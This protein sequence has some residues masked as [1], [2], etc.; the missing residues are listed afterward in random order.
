MARAAFERL[1]T[2]RPAQI[3]LGMNL[4]VELD[5]ARIHGIALG[6]ERRVTLRETDRFRSL[7]GGTVVARMA[8][9]TETVRRC[10]ERHSSVVFAMARRTRRRRCG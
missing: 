9:H 6:G 5:R 10:R 1:G 7:G 4:V 8:A 2:V 3:G